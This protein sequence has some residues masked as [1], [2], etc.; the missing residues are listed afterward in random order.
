MNASKVVACGP[1][2]CKP[3]SEKAVTA[4]CNQSKRSIPHMYGV[5]ADYVTIYEGPVA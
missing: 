3:I 4:D 1:I 5:A 2:G